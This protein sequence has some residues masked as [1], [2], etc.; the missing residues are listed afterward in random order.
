MKNDLINLFSTDE[1]QTRKLKKWHKQ[2]WR[3]YY[4]LFVSKEK[5][6]QQKLH[7]NLLQKKH[8]AKLWNIFL[9]Q[10]FQNKLEY[11]QLKPKKELLNQKIIWQY[12]GQGLEQEKLPDLVKLCFASVDEYK[13]DYQV[14]RLDEHTIREYLDLPDFVWE[15]KKNPQFKPAFFADLLR[16]A[17]LD[18]YGGVWIDA[19][20]LLT[21]PIEQKLLSQDF[22]MFHR[23]ET[24]QNKEFWQEFNQDYFGWNDEH[25]VNVLNS[26]IVSK[27]RNNIVHICLDVMLNYWKTQINI[28]HYFFFQIMFNEL[29]NHYL[30][31]ESMQILDDTKVHLLQIIQND[32][33]NQEQYDLILK[34]MGIHKLNYVK[35]LQQESYYEYLLSIYKI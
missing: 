22:F 13:A 7:A 30:T 17:L 11:F 14:I 9:E 5:R 24:V 15:K 20:I 1:E 31:T 28:P 16:L 10:Y 12:W 2:P 3:T 8:V 35:L 21:A 4:S 25:Y 18:V 29:M 33:F 19:T 34:Q 6:K 23:D 26:F 32:R 27:C